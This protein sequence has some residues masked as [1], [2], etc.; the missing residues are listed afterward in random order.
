MKVVGVEPLESPL[1]TGGVAGPH[2][3][4]GI[5]ANFIPEILD[6]DVYDEVIDV[7]A[8]QAVAMARRLGAEEGILGGISS[9]PPPTPRWNWPTV[10]NSRGRLLLSSWPVLESVISPLFCM[11]D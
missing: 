11:K 4:Q 1:L 5:G 7:T 3:I 2:K 10:P 8:E 9:G 6:R